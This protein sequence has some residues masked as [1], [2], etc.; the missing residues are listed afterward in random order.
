MELLKLAVLC[1]LCVLPVT[2][3]RR[4]TPE[5]A[6]LLT[7]A[8]LAAAA[9]STAEASAWLPPSLHRSAQNRV[10]SAAAVTRSKTAMW[11][12][13]TPARANSAPISSISGAA[14]ARHRASAAARTSY[15][16]RWILI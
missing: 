11:A 14:A 4:K 1:A 12:V 10:T 2:L 7:A 8:V 15:C 3:L 5:Q 16:K 9:V 13:S 6:L